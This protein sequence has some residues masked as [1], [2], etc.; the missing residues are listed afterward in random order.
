MSRSL[1]TNPVL[2]TKKAL[3]IVRLFY[4]KTFQVFITYWPNKDKFYVGFTSDNIDER[5]RKYNSNHKSFTDKLTS[6]QQ[7]CV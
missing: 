5:I 3:Q 1:A 4:Y 6:W 7:K 2:P